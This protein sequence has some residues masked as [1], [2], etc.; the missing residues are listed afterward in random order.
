[1]FDE[2]IAKLEKERIEFECSHYDAGWNDAINYII[3]QYLR[4]AQHNVQPTSDRAGD[5]QSKESE[6][7]TRG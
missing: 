4:A 7:V 5:N 2:L 6:A 3:Y 1:M